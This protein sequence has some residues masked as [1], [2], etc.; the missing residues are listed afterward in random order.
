MLYTVKEVAKILKVCTKTVTN[1]L[2]DGTIKGFKPRGQ[3]RIT[4]EELERIKEG[5]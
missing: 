4:S 1:W 2:N 5:K 3:W